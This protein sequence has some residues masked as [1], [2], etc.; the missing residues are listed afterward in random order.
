[1]NEITI[2]NSPEFGQIRTSV[3]E[4]N[5]PLFCAADVCEALG[6]AN[7]RK[8]IADHIDEGDVTKRYTWVV[9]GKKSDGTEAKRET[10]M[11]YVTESGLY[12]L[13][14]GSKL[15]SAK[16]F[17]RWVTSEVLPSIRKMGGYMVHRNDETPEQLMA[18]ALEVARQTLE[19]AEKE[20]Q[21]LANANESQRITIGIQDKELKKSAPK[22][23]YYDR[24]LQSTC[25]MTMTQVAKGLGMECNKLTSKLKE[26]GLIY[27][28]SGQWLLRSPY[29]GWNL[30]STRTSTYTHSDG[31]IGTSQYT[32]W[33]ERGRR[34]ITAL[35]E[36]DFDMRSAIKNI[37]DLELPPK[38]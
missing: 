22:V 34:L 1:M 32:V 11:T 10:L 12:S 29:S 5:E 19:R 17:K 2:F 21:E 23:D 3:A 4:N 6:Y 36:C 27:R 16:N 15:P 38:M 30:H 24:T 25:T 37:Q 7:N 18:R 28:Q 14:F 20:N 9:T 8:A 26:A 13:I 35:K 31:S 33:N